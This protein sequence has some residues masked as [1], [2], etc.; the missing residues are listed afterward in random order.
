[1]LIEQFD[2]GDNMTK[3][4]DKLIQILEEFLSEGEVPEYDPSSG[5]VY[6]LNEGQRRT[7]ELPGDVKQKVLRECKQVLHG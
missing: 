1:M 3:K 4:N 2:K 7:L 5:E 6:A